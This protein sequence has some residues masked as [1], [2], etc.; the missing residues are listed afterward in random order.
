MP[1]SMP[2]VSRAVQKRGRRFRP[3]Y[4]VS[5]RTSLWEKQGT[6]QHTCRSLQEGK[7]A[8]LWQEFG[9]TG[10]SR[11]AQPLRQDSAGLT[12]PGGVYAPSSPGS[13]P[14]FSSQTCP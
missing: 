9:W 7:G 14:G 1:P 4:L 13:S 6:A 3:V 12:C 5:A 2:A 10:D 11:P 8:G